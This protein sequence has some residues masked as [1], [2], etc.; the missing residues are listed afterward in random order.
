VIAIEAARLDPQHAWQLL[1]ELVRAANASDD[2]AGDESSIEIRT[3]ENS[4]VVTETPFTFTADV[5]RLDTI[6]ATMAH[7]DFERAL[8]SARAL[9]GHVPRAFAQLAIA[10]A[11]LERK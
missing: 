5:F 4:E 7:L 3:D 1:V 9:E 2:F 8:S 10:R 6:F 11:A